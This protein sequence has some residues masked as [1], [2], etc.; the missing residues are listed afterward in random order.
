MRAGKAVAGTAV[1]VALI[2]VTAACSKNTGKTGP[3]SGNTITFHLAPSQP[4]FPYAASWG[5]TA[6]L[7]RSQDKN[8]NAIDT[9][10]FSSGPYQIASYH[11]A[12]S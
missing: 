9:H 7:P 12:T 11:R 1:A 2:G 4:E 3:G 6:P 10:P 8:P 5:T